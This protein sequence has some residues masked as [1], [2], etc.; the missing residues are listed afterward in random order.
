MRVVKIL[1]G[2]AVLAG[3]A[4]CATGDIYRSCASS[5][6]ANGEQLACTPGEEDNYAHWDSDRI[7][8]Q[9]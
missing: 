5:V 2:F 9:R 3:L 4:G 1:M 8:L 7:S 6:G